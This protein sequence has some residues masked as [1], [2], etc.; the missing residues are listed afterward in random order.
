M[1]VA[2]TGRERAQL[3]SHQHRLGRLAEPRAKHDW[4]I[5]VSFLS[6]AHPVALAETPDA[7]GI[8]LAVNQG[9][10]TVVDLSP[11][12]LSTVATIPVGSAPVWMVARGDNQRVYA[13]TQGDGALI[14]G[15]LVPIDAASNTILPS[16]TNLSVGS[17][18]QFHFVRFKSQP[19]LRNQSHDGHSLRVLGH[20]RG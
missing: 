6:G 15:K 19:A 4:T 13:L 2:N 7:Q 1:Y 5:S 12:D 16:Q 9:N 18:R 11:I 8:Y 20:R 14:P 17:G 3:Q 10:N